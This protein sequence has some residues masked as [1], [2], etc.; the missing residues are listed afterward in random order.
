MEATCD[1]KSRK[2]T[3]SPSFSN[4]LEQDLNKSPDGGQN[5]GDNLLGPLIC[6]LPIGL[7]NDPSYGKTW[8]LTILQKRERVERPCSLLR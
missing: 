6:A 5:A 8:V 4:S 3:V 7:G 2:E 1:R